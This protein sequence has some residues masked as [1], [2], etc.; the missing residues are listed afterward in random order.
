MAGGDGSQALVA[1]VA[2]QHDVPHV[3]LPACTR[4][5]VALRLGLDR[6]DVARAAG[7]ANGNNDGWD[8]GGFRYSGE[9][10]VGDL[11][12]VGGNAATATR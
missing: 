3:C 9:G 12:F 11:D 5:H 8:E 10:R 4:H 6:D 7:T 1:S 2:A